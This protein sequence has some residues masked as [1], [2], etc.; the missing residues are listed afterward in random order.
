MIKPG[1]LAATFACVKG[2]DRP[3]QT[4]NYFQKGRKPMI[5][6]F[7]KTGC[8]CGAMILAATSGRTEEKKSP[9]TLDLGNG[10][11]VTFYGY[12]KADFISDDGYE[13]GDTTG[14]IRSIGL[15]GG[16]AAGSFDTATLRE[17]RIGFN[18]NGPDD[19]FA[20]FEGDFY[21]PNDN[22]RL[23]HA[24]L[25]WKGVL[26][27]QNWTNFMSVENLAPTVDFQGSGALPF[28]RVP[29]LRYTF[30]P[31]SNIKFS[32]SVEE[33]IANSSDVMLT[34]A[35]RYGFDLGMVRASALWRDTT[36]GG[37]PVDGWGLSL[38]T[39]LKPWQGGQVQFAVTTGD[40]AVDILGAGLSGTAVVLG[41]GP[42]GFD[43][44]ALSISQKIGDKLR[45]AVTGSWVS[46]DRSVGTDTSE[47]ETVHLSAF[48]EVF[49]NTTLMAEYFTGQRTQANGIDF[50]TDRVQLA[51][52]FAF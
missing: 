26:I 5:A 41:G 31:S 48:Y 49:R 28:A 29:Q 42:V 11:S 1:P 21:G 35:L 7:L 6:R 50:D 8:L 32:A 19:V 45:L 37:T 52:K 36:I 27:G 38:A 43:S 46:L 34:A 30:D 39:V 10:V 24:Y 23:R 51:V 20:K 12:V 25:D 2:L 18:I 40:G 3:F 47:L 22:L 13:L 15:P 14:A 9:L 17:T 44:A 4:G 33:D 16:P